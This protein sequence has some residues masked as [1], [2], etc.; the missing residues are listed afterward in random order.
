MANQICPVVAAPEPTGSGMVLMEEGANGGICAKE[1]WENGMGMKE[2][3][4][5]KRRRFGFILTPFLFRV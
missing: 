5:M 2:K 1:V 4:R 3:K